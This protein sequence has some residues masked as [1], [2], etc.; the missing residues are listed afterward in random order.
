MKADVELD[1]TGDS[2]PM[3]FVRTKVKLETM[4]PGEL[5]CVRLRGGEPLVNVPRAVLDHGHGIVAT[6]SLEDGVFALWIEV[7]A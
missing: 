6:E 2:C 3:T 1:I 5:L 7:R 4:A